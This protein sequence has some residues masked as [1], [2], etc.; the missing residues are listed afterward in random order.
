MIKEFCLQGYNAVQFVIS[1]KTELF[2]AIIVRISNPT[3]NG[4]ILCGIL[5]LKY[6][7]KIYFL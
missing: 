5:S 6:E 4:E 7:H 3:E 2:L 1:Q